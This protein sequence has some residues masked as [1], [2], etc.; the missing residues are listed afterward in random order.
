MADERGQLNAKTRLL[1]GLGAGVIKYILL[2]SANN[3]YKIYS[4]KG[5]RGNFC[6]Y[7]SF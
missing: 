7:L 4:F 1:C 2:L 3:F 5:F 6:W